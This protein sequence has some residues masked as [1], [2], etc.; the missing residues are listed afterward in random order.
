MEE[1]NRRKREERGLEPVDGGGIEFGGGASDEDE[2]E[3]GGDGDGDDAGAG[4]QEGGGEVERSDE[5]E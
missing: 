3:E 2:D 1:K 4:E 5:E